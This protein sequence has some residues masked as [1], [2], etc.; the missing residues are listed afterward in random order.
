MACLGRICLILASEYTWSTGDSGSL[1]LMGGSEKAS[2]YF[3]RGVEVP[4]CRRTQICAH[5]RCQS[6]E[7]RIRNFFM[8]DRVNSRRIMCNFLAWIQRSPD[9][10]VTDSLRIELRHGFTG[11]GSSWSSIGGLEVAVELDPPVF[12][13][14]FALVCLLNNP[15]PLWEGKLVAVNADTSQGIAHSTSVFKATAFA[16]SLSAWL[17]LRGLFSWRSKKSY[18]SWKVNY[19]CRFPVWF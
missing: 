5:R 17:I 14:Q 9:I 2:T 19:L 13:I 12:A 15:Y 11:R 8:V 10:S 3:F 1:R 16:T 7:R 4:N 18:A 6:T